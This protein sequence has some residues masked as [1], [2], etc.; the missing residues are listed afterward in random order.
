MQYYFFQQL[1]VTTRRIIN[2]DKHQIQFLELRQELLQEIKYEREQQMEQQTNVW[3]LQKTPWVLVQ[4]TGFLHLVMCWI[5]G[6]T[7]E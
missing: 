5:R 1:P 3:D 2:T 4:K 7:K 6:Y